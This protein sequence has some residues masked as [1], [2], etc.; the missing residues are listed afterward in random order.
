MSGQDFNTRQSTDEALVAFA[1]EQI[2]VADSEV[3]FTENT[4]APDNASGR[5]WRT[6]RL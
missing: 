3:G 5:P 2:T 6:E 1:F 4:Y